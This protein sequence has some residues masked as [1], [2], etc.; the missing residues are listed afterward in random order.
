MI[1]KNTFMLMKN[2]NL[3]NVKKHR[4]IK[5]VTG[6]KRRNYLVSET[7]YHAVTFFTE[8][9]LAIELNKTEILRNKTVYFGL[10]ILKLNRIFGMIM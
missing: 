6:E 5:L 10:L 7:N 9:L 3:D 2:S 8:H 4:D 1:W